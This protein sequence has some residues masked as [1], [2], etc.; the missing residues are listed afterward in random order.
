LVV[1]QQIHV[2][3]QINYAHR[4]EENSKP[5]ERTKK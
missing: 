4:T 5:S 2:S 1:E 3:E